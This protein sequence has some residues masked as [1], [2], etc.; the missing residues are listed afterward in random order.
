[1]IPCTFEAEGLS[2]SLL[3]SLSDGME[4]LRS[5]PIIV[6]LVLFVAGVTALASFTESVGNLTELFARP[7]PEAARAE[8]SKLGIPY[9]AESLQGKARDGDLTAVKKLLQAGLPADAVSETAGSDAPNEPALAEA[10][11]RGDLAMV[12]T[13]LASHADPNAGVKPA[14]VHAHNAVLQLLL[15]Q[16]TSERTIQEALISAA[17]EMK[18]DVVRMLAARLANPKPAL[19]EALW[20][21]SQST[22][23]GAA[24]LT[25][26]DRALF[27]LGAD[28]NTADVDGITPLM[29]AA[30]SGPAEQVRV[31][32]EAGANANARCTCPDFFGGGWTA[33]GLAARANDADKVTRLIAAGADVNARNAEGETP[34]ILASRHPNMEA[35]KALLKANADVQVRA[36]NGQN[37]VDIASRGYVWP[38]KTVYFP[39]LVQLLS[40]YA[41][42]R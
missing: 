22:G 14:A 29:L 18:P 13:L 35:I 10:A 24:E 36:G 27:Q 42:K 28:P 38:D 15:K 39:E 33:L 30:E 26:L 20:R 2:M 11:G 5:N 7:T 34:L 1:M 4:K 21:M 9:T 19:S 17:S 41:G 32:I 3:K 31:L 8:L 25:A 23:W 40:S 12:Q 16:Q 37:A 6:A